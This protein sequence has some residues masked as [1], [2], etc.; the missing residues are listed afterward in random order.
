MP[1]EKDVSGVAPGSLEGTRS[2][3]GGESGAVAEV[4]RWSAGRK[5]EAVLGLLRGKPVDAT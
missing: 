5:K 4:K 3:S 1:N 2:A